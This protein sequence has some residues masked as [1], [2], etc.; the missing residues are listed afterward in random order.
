LPSGRI[1]TLGGTQ[2]HIPAGTTVT[3]ATVGHGPRSIIDGEYLSRLFVVEGS[4][5]LTN[6]HL[7]HGSAADEGG[8]I[9]ALQS[10]SVHMTGCVVANCTASSSSSQVSTAHEIRTASRHPSKYQT[11]PSADPPETWT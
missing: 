1:Y 7:K 2:I 5:Q 6:V 3:I 8:G 10:S 11:P 9:L 4:L